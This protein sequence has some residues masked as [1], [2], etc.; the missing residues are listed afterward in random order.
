M[1]SAAHDGIGLKRDPAGRD[2]NV[3]ALLSALA[4]AP[5]FTAAPS[6]LVTQLAELA[7]ARRA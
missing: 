2:R 6:F 7:G 3:A 1:G 5:E 4:A